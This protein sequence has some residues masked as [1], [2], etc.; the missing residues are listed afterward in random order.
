MKYARNIMGESDPIN[1]LDYP[2]LLPDDVWV[3]WVHTGKWPDASRTLR[4]LSRT[5]TN[6]MRGFALLTPFYRDA[7]RFDNESDAREWLAAQNTLRP[8]PWTGLRVTTVAQLKLEHGF[9][10]ETH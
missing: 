2:A 9:Y 7:Q 6:P 3:L 4:Y 8:T 5:Q 1:A 10:V